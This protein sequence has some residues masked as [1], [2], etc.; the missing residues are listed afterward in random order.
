MTYHFQNKE[1]VACNQN[2]E[3]Y[4]KM[5]EHVNHVMREKLFHRS[6]NTNDTSIVIPDTYLKIATIDV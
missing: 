4:G 2:C 1:S 3:I 6:R 5:Q